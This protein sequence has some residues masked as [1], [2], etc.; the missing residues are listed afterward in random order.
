MYSAVLDLLSMLSRKQLKSFLDYLK[1]PYFNKNKE[2]IFL[3]DKIITQLLEG[4]PL[5]SSFWNSIY[6]RY[7]G[8]VSDKRKYLSYQFNRIKQHLKQYFFLEYQK[9]QPQYFRHEIVKS[10][11]YHNLSTFFSKDIENLIND[12]NTGKT[13][14]NDS[15]ANFQVFYLQSEERRIRGNNRLQ[16]EN[17]VSTGYNEFYKF[18]YYIELRKQIDFYRGQ[19]YF[20]FQDSGPENLCPIIK[21]NIKSNGLSSMVLI[22]LYES[23][24]NMYKNIE[25]V[26]YYEKF[27]RELKSNNNYITDDDYIGL[28]TSALSYY[29]YYWLKGNR[30]L[31]EDALSLRKE[32][33]DRGYYKRKVVIFPHELYDLVISGI[34]T[35]KFNWAKKIL[36]KNENKL[37]GEDKKM[38]INY[39]KGLLAQSEKQFTLALDYYNKI[40]KKMPLKMELSARISKVSIFYQLSEIEML[41]AHLNSFRNFVYRNNSLSENRK[42]SYFTFIKYVKKLIRVKNIEETH[43]IHHELENEEVINNKFW[44]KKMLYEKIKYLQ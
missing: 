1:S 25:D 27:M 7:S 12:I 14:Y 22:N 35:K 41:I 40:D 17:L 38:H 16:F 43:K 44:I 20:S 39:L 23:V 37:L 11:H 2:L 26:G 24:L 8:S 31:K 18:I 6:K 33:L 19:I 28:V 5:D 36:N 13:S 9:E 42:I 30:S 21:D 4:K 34:N 10:L 32:M 3:G 15:W 29:N